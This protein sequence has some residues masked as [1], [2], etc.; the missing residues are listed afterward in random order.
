[1]DGEGNRVVVGYVAMHDAGGAVTEDTGL[2][3][4]DIPKVFYAVNE[5][6][7]GVVAVDKYGAV[8]VGCGVGIEQGY[9]EEQ[10]V[11]G[12]NIWVRLAV[13]SD[14]RYQHAGDGTSGEAYVLGGLYVIVVVA[15]DGEGGVFEGVVNF[16]RQD[17][18]RRKGEPLGQGGGGETIAAMIDVG[19]KMP[20]RRGVLD[21]LVVASHQR[22]PETVAYKV[23]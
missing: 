6:H 12:I 21:E 17:A 19:G 16:S 23:H 20:G 9:V 10:R 3:G 2:V 5:C 15:G 11:A 8:V 22:G 4:Q 14:I 7:E 1:M 13:H 18:I